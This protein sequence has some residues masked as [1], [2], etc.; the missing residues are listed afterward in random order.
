MTRQD[1][2]HSSGRNWA[3]NSNGFWLLESV[4]PGTYD[5]EIIFAGDHP[6]GNATVRAGAFS[7]SLKIKANEIRGHR[8]QV[9]VAGKL[10]LSV[11]VEFDGKVQGPHQV[12]LKRVN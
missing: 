5:V 2:R 8:T 1:W 12:I 3:P 11:D 6:A 9:K 4:D 7:T 10:K